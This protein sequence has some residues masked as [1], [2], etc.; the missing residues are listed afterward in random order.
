MTDLPVR[1]TDKRTASYR[2]YILDTIIGALEAVFDADY[3]RDRQFVNLKILA[4]YSRDE[5][6]YPCIVVS[7][8]GR[9]VQNMGVGHE[10][11]FDDAANIRRKWHHSFFEGTIN[12]EIY[13]LTTMD[14]DILQDGLI[15]VLRFGRLDPELL[16]FFETIYGSP[17]D[18]VRLIFNQIALNTDIV[19]EQANSVSVAPW[20]AEDQLLYTTGC[21]LEVKGGY[22]NITPDISWSFVERVTAHSYP[23]FEEKVTI[24]LINDAPDPTP[25][26]SDPGEIT[27][28][29]QFYDDNT[30]QDPTISVTDPPVPN[31]LKGVGVIS[32]DEVFEDV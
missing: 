10:E 25:L 28:P 7:Y 30:M 3:D 22:Y 31:T 27:N 16:P 2:R 29:R 20:N 8:D 23:Q 15:E 5:Q 18:P 11:W 1:T 24:P 17:D 9:S 14:R 12:F 26:G 6:D 4:Q 19:N 32:G 21:S 13:A